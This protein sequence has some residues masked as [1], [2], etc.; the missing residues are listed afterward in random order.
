MGVSTRDSW[1]V[2]TLLMSVGSGFHKFRESDAS[3]TDCPYYNFLLF[4]HHRLQQSPFNHSSFYH[5]IKSLPFVQ[6]LLKL[7]SFKQSN[8]S[9]QNSETNSTCFYGGKSIHENTIM[10]HEILS[11]PSSTKKGKGV[12]QGSQIG[13][14][15]CL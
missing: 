14:G 1:E 12:S 2:G 15:K 11:T 3:S 10:A 13:H 8:N 4:V 7:K 5:K 9:S 6:S